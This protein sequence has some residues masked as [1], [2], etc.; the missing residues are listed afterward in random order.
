[1]KWP[2][3]LSLQVVYS[4]MW[5]ILFGG[6]GIRHERKAA[7]VGLCCSNEDSTLPK[8]NG[9]SYF[10]NYTM[11]NDTVFGDGIQSD[12]VEGDASSW[13]CD[14]GSCNKCALQTIGRS[15]R[16]TCSSNHGSNYL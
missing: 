13:I 5:M 6:I 15:V 10:I 7:E 1:M 14:T 11:L 4:F 3:P 12:L 2:L 8:W 9:S 16:I